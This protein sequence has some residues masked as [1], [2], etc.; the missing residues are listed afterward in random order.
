[1]S[2]QGI[3]LKE[4]HWM[5]DIL[6]NIDVGLVVLDKRYT[7][8]IWNGFMENHSGIP[9]EDARHRQIFELFPELP[10]DWFKNKVESVFLLNNRA[11][12]IWE[13]RPHVFPFRNYRPITGTEELMFQNTTIIPLASVD[14]SVNHVCVIVYDL[15]DAAVSK[16]RLKNANTK[17][18]ILSRTDGLTQL[19]NR[20]F[21]EECLQTEFKRCGRTG[22]T[23]SVVM[24]DIDHFKHINDTHGHQ[25]GDE[26][27][28]HTAALLR[29]TVRETDIA[30]RYG[31]EEFVA[32]LIDTNVEGALVFG[33]RLRRRAAAASVIY[34]GV[35]MR[36]TISLGVSANTGSR[37]HSDWLAQAD[38]ALY[39]AKQTGRNRACRAD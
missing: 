32:I 25:A 10:R 30:G 23:S 1:M 5:M 16:K 7:V 37:T 2:G 19:N 11:F 12:T 39:R 4:L 34:G 9:P 6:Q 27:I 36:Y 26:V 21:W 3:E 13:Q 18:E 31:G 14:G 28:R 8:Q 20:A 17:L 38:Q 35:D 29:N 24:L 33:E 22:T 15:T